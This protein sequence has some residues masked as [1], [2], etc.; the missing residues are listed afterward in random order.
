MKTYNLTVGGTIQIDP[1][2]I[3]EVSRASDG[4]ATITLDPFGFV[5]LDN[6]FR[7]VIRDIHQALIEQ[8]LCDA[9]AIT[10]S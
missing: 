3:R 7:D 1:L 9:D 10:A 2:S 8:V 5:P 4:T 6:S